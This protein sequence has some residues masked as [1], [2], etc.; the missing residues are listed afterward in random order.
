SPDAALAVLALDCREDETTV[1]LV[2]RRFKSSVAVDR[3]VHPTLILR[4]ETS[5]ERTVWL[6]SSRGGEQGRAAPGRQRRRLRTLLRGSPPGARGGKW[7]E[8][9]MRPASERYP[10]AERRVMDAESSRPVGLEESLCPGASG[11]R[12]EQRGGGS[13]GKTARY[14]SKRGTK[15]AA[16]PSAARGRTTHLNDRDGPLG[17]SGHRG[18]GTRRNQ[19]GW[20]R[21]QS[22]RRYPAPANPRQEGP[23]TCGEKESRLGMSVGELVEMS[24]K[25][26]IE[27]AVATDIGKG[28]EVYVDYGAGWDKS[29]RDFVQMH[30][31]ERAGYFW[32]ERPLWKACIPRAGSICWFSNI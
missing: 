31:Y 8:V 5:I 2:L 12:G 28:S 3:E 29:W 16:F 21:D 14:R 30:P 15:L 11:A 13:G 6:A 23:P 10:S 27:Y 18:G 22:G 19:W 32:R 24:S 7:A 17:A 26:A 1:S 4:E 20:P 9:R 25:I